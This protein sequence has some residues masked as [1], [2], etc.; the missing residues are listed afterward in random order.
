MRVC[1]LGVGG[2]SVDKSVGVETT[3]GGGRRGMQAYNSL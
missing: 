1:E 3:E 2:E